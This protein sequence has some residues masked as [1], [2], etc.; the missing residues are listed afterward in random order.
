MD[1][2]TWREQD[3]GAGPFYYHFLSRCDRRAFIYGKYKVSVKSFEHHGQWLINRI[4]QV[5][6]VFDVFMPSCRT[7]GPRDQMDTWSQA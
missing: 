7:I 3:A 1:L 5:I 6:S 2:G 4:K